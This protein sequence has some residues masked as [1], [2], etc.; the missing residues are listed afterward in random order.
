MHIQLVSVGSCAVLKLARESDE[1][2]SVLTTGLDTV[3]VYIA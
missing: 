1:A 3:R 2:I